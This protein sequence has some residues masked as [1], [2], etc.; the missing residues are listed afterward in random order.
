M[1]VRLLKLEE[2]PD[3]I[4][5]A[6][7]FYDEHYLDV[8]GPFNAEFFHK[9]WHEFMLFGQALIFVEHDGAVDRGC[10]GCTRSPNIF[11]G[12]KTYMGMFTAVKPEHRGGL[13]VLH[14]FEGVHRLIQAFG[15]PARI[16]LS[17]RVPTLQAI[18]QRLGYEADSVRYTRRI[19]P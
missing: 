15:E 14:L 12:E 3:V 10:F 11:T 6:R 19:I 9:Q 13:V 16:F 5:D 18:W 4:D 7:A 8:Y 2:L 17:S 1:A